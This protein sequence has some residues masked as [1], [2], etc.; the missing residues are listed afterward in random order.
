MKMPENRPIFQVLIAV[1]KDFLAYAEPEL[2][3][4]A[5]KDLEDQFKKIIGRLWLIWTSF[6]EE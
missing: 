2:F 5:M 6:D 4:R 3:T 1:D